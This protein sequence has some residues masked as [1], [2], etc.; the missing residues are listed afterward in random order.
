MEPIIR[1]TYAVL[2]YKEGGKLAK[3][4]G[5]DTAELK[6]SLIS[7]SEKHQEGEKEKDWLRFPD[8]ES[9]RAV[10]DHAKRQ[11][12]GAMVYDIK[13]LGWV[14]ILVDC[15]Y[16]VRLVDSM[17]RGD[18]KMAGYYAVL[19]YVS[20]KLYRLSGMKELQQKNELVFHIQAPPINGHQ[21]NDWYRVRDE[22]SQNVIDFAKSP[23]VKGV[24]YNL[25]YEN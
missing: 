7:Y 21:E 15:Q 25:A 11:P 23:T 13:E 14:F 1:A 5:V 8:E 18:I 6:E 20:N 12:G 9:I 17:S 24:T 10:I 19:F 2:L 22:Y 4:V 16:V 3:V